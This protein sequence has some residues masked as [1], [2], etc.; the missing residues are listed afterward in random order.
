MA[1]LRIYYIWLQLVLGPG[2]GKL[3]AVL[4]RFGGAEALHHADSASRRES[5]IFSPAEIQKINKIPLDAADRILENCKKIGCLVFT[6]EDEAYPARLFNTIDPP[7]ALYVAGQWPA[8]DDEAAVTVVGARRPT[9]DGVSA[10]ASLAARL[11]RAGMLIVSGGALGIDYAAHM[12]ALAAGGRTVCVMPCGVDCNYPSQNAEMRRLVRE[13]GCLISEYPPGTP[14]PRGAFQARN[15]LLSGLSL[16]TVVIEAGKSS[17][18]L[19]TA[20]RAVEQGRDVYVV[21]G[22][23]GSPVY[24][25]SN[26]LIQD[27]AAPLLDA[28]DILTAY[29]PDY[30]HKLNLRQAA[31]PFSKE[32]LTRL[33]DLLAHPHVKTQPDSPPEKRRMPLEK[34]TVPSR[35][36]SAIS[37]PQTP[38]PKRPAGDELSSAAAQIYDAMEAEPLSADYLSV[39]CGVEAGAVLAAL[40]ELELLGYIRPVPGGRF[41]PC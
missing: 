27:G 2:S 18:T 5:G 37:T 38:V 16:G 29:A 11:A 22:P 41:E 7:C 14:V 31:E 32:V 35:P 40:T 19:I 15:R 21:P 10:A 30:P 39:K 23:V 36:K 1:D 25:G 26:R 12:G 17:G 8:I 24:A 9:G 3:P 33:A 34:P 4:R 28:A 13:R 6:P 20:H